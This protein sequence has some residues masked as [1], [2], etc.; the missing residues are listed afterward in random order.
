MGMRILVLRA[1][2]DELGPATEGEL[3]ALLAD[4]RNLVWVDMW[5][6]GPRERGLLEAT[7]GAHP[8]TVS[9][10]LGDA[11]L[12]KLE[13]IEGAGYVVLESIV[14][15]ERGR[16]H[17]IETD[18]NDFLLGPSWIVSNRAAQSAAFDAA[19]DSMR[20]RPSDLRRGPAYVLY[21][22]AAAIIETFA[23]LA[24]E[25]E[26]EAEA[27]DAGITRKAGPHV[28]EQV[29]ATKQRLRRLRSVCTHQRDVLDRLARDDSGLVPDDVRP[30]LRDVHDRFVRI[31]ERI[32]G[33]RELADGALEAYVSI[34]GHR[35][36][37]V[38]KVLTAAVAT[39]HRVAPLL[40]LSP[41]GLPAAPHPH[42]QSRMW[43]PS[44]RAA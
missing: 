40:F 34:N 10:M 14:P 20:R 8:A 6:P 39:L 36:N 7:F 19:L 4:P 43:G 3:G 2:E 22:L 5:S 30:F 38:M 17:E 42:R 33:A 16:P 44:R 26:A 32:E 37:E 13:H 27:L 9:D 11:P 29:S 35:M 31:A 21:R 23:P 1:G 15:H 41:E 28:I 24:A 12:P 25:L 18:D